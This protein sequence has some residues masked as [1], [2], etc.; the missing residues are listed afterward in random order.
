MDVSE[1]SLEKITQR[2]IQTGM[3]SQK[4]QH[5]GNPGNIHKSN[6]TRNQSETPSEGQEDQYTYL[7][8]QAM[9]VNTVLKKPVVKKIFHHPGKIPPVPGPLRI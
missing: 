5:E 4:I 8:S 6:V 9:Y 1:R 2:E 3:D 7:E